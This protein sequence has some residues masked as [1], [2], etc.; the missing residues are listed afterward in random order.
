VARLATEV[1]RADTIVFLGF[2]FHTQNMLILKPAQQ[3]LPKDIY[4]TAFGMSDALRK[5]AAKRVLPSADPSRMNPTT[6]IVGCCAC[7]A[8]GHAA[9]EA[10]I[11][12]MDSRRLIAPSEALD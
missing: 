2:A 6:G 1:T 7:A 10:A 3:M 12:L 5:A 4:G 9:A 11:T 8:S